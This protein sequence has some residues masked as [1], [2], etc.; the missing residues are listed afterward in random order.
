M[1]TQGSLLTAF[2]FQPESIPTMP[3]SDYM[4]TTPEAF[5]SDFYACRFTIKQRDVL[6]SFI[7]H[8]IEMYQVVAEKKVVVAQL[9][10]IYICLTQL[11]FHVDCLCCSVKHNYYDHL[12]QLQCDALKPIKLPIVAEWQVSQIFD[13]WNSPIATSM[14]FT[15]LP[16]FRLLGER[17]VKQGTII[18]SL[19]TTFLQHI[20][21][22]QRLYIRYVDTKDMSVFGYSDV[23]FGISDQ[24]Q[25]YALNDIDFRGSYFNQASITDTDYH[26][27]PSMKNAD[28]R[29]SSWIHV[30]HS[31]ENGVFVSNLDGSDFTNSY[32]SPPEKVRAMLKT[33]VTF[34]DQP[35]VFPPFKKNSCYFNYQSPAKLRST[36]QQT[37]CTLL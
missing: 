17:G 34:A 5:V 33:Y 9:K 32:V 31:V 4:Y 3:I 6:P 29:Y 25:S 26:Y 22:T 13:Y 20:T 16:M 14:G 7:H 23:I 36:K 15:C 1:F 10:F 27:P 37:G 21:K 35:T 30:F 24:G 12:Y 8:L 19:L 11:H 2:P 28:L 18:M